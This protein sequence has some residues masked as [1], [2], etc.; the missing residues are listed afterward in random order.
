MYIPNYSLI[1]SPVY[2]VTQTKNDFKWGPEQW[3]AFEKNQTGHSLCRRSWA[4]LDTAR[5]KKCAQNTAKRNVSP[6]ILW[7]K[8]P[9]ETLGQALRFLCLGYRGSEVCYTPTK[10]ENSGLSCFRN[11]LY[12]STAPDKRL[13]VSAGLDVSKERSPLHIMQMILLTQSKWVT[14][15]TQLPWIE[16]PSHSGILEVVMDY[17]ES[18]DFIMSLEEEV[19]SAENFLVGHQKR[20]IVV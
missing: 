9:G 19:T 14:L 20:T 15:I 6:W 4:T 13:P 8:I 16:N 11:Y 5:H 18:K 17:P 7:Q 12:W 10:K 1:F 3:R 2:Q